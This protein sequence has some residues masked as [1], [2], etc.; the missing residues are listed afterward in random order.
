MAAIPADLA[1]QLRQ[2]VGETGWV[3]DE[4]DLAPYLEERRG[5]YT[6][7]AQM[8]LRPANT[9]ELADLVKACAAAG[10]AM[11][12]QGGNTGLVGGS[13]TGGGE[14]LINL[15]RMNRIRSVDAAN[16]TMTVDAGCILADVQDAA[17]QADRLFPLSLGA[18]GSCQIGGVLSTNAGGTGVLRYGPARDLVLGLEVVLADGQVWDGLGGL[19]KDNTGYDLKNIFIGAEGTLGFISAAT[20]RLFP[21]PRD[22][23]TSLCAVPTMTAAVHLLGLLNAAA[24]ETL[25]GMEIMNAHSV[26]F[27]V[28]HVPGLKQPLKGGFPWFVLAEL[29]SAREV[30]GLQAVLEAMLATAHETAL[31]SDATVASNEQQ[32]ANLWALREAMPEGQKGEGGSIKH[33]ISVPISRLAEFTAAAD[34]AVELALP[35]IRPVTFGHIGDGNLHYNLTQPEGTDADFFM[36]EA[37]RLNTIVHDL[38]ANMDGSISAEHGVGILKR[39]EI[40]RRK[41]AVEMDLM[42]A[43]KTALD[44]KGLMNPGKVV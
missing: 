35:G 16:S 4:S 25:S 42:R 24:G 1:A 43:L 2:I 9:A 29:T 7:Q 3:E 15:G 38:V 27:A 28:R 37:P 20:L 19:R 21:R 6:S 5:T 14:V 33:D 30:G 44:P 39:D 12:P 34:E 31:V 18:E 17:A 41:S 32:R 23:A 11:V 22:T 13:V 10:V 36:A 40:A 8:M 26:E